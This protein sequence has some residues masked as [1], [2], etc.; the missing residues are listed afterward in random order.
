MAKV[1]GRPCKQCGT[2][3][4]S[5]SE[6][7]WRCVR[8]NAEDAKPPRICPY[9]QTEK[10]REIPG[11][12]KYHSKC[13]FAVSDISKKATAKVKK[14]IKDGEIHAISTETL[15]VDCGKPAR[16]YDHRY[17]SKPLDV[18][19]VCRACNQKRGPAL[20]VHSFYLAERAQ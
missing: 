11:A 13:A 9:C 3:N 15:C 2:V 1:A 10:S 8:K 12:S 6:I 16:D 14:A 20:D 7:C 19:P 17:Y 5:F 18:V 4:H